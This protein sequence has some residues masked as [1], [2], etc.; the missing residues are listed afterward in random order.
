MS[1]DFLT[2]SRGP[3]AGAAPRGRKVAMAVAGLATALGLA[4]ALWLGSWAFDM[5]RYSYHVGRLERLQDKK[6]SIGLVE[7]AF[8]DAEEGSPLL[9][10]AEGAEELRAIAARHAGTSAA[11]V[12]EKGRPWSRTRV[13]AAPDMLYFIFFDDQGIMRD[14]TVV[15]R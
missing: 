10:K 3:L 1:E 6:P 5:R 12:V 8:E 11:A 2:P 15:S 13:F 9:A 14:F 7:R 4:G